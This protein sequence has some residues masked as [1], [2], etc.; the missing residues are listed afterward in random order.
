MTMGL[1]AELSQRDGTE[2]SPKTIARVLTKLKCTSKPGLL[3][4]FFC[5][6]TRPELNNAA[7]VLR[8]L[9]YLLVVQIEDLFQHVQKRYRAVGKQL[10]EGS[11]A[12]FALQEILSNILN[13]AS[14]PTTYLLVDG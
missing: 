10:F 3:D 8:G 7:S 9:I 11:N 13:D 14:L 5:Q 6:S 12:I 1:V 4:Y 2:P